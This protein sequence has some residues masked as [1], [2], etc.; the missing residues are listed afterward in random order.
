M[1]FEFHQRPKA[2]IGSAGTASKSAHAPAPAA[3][4]AVGQPVRQD[5]LGLVP[6]DG[7]GHFA[8]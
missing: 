3:P 8:A 1:V 2:M 5:A 6:L 4:E 7:G